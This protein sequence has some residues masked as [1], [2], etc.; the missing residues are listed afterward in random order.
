MPPEIRYHALVH[1]QLLMKNPV[2]LQTCIQKIIQRLHLRHFIALGKHIVVCKVYHAFQLLKLVPCHGGR[3][4]GHTEV[5][6]RRPVES[7]FRQSMV[8]RKDNDANK[9]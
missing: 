3:Y 8:P 7:L 1:T 6:A 2:L 5:G 9:C 4:N